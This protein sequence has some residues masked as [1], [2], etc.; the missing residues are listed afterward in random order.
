MSSLSSSSSSSSSSSDSGGASASASA[1]GSNADVV[2]LTALE[3]EIAEL[4]AK[5]EGYE[6]DVV[7]IKAGTG[8][9]E[10]ISNEKKIDAIEKKEATI[11]AR[12]NN[13]D[14][15]LAEKALLVQQQSQPLAGK[16][17]HL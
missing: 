4:K 6:K 5:I 3:N 14:K 11:T 1:S 8:M 12:G 9:Y 10:G 7:D 13:L 17:M 16:L 2:R 15:L